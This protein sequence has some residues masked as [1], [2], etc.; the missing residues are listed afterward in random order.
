MF[1]QE[2]SSMLLLG[3]F[4]YLL[5]YRAQRSSGTT[6]H[7]HNPLE[8]AEMFRHCCASFIVSTDE[9]TDQHQRAET[10]R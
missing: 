5:F 10:W 8:G 2:R 3:L 9:D 7:P 4:S 1:Q 6:L